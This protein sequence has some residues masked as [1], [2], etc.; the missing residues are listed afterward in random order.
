[1]SLLPST[2]SSIPPLLP[3]VPTTFSPHPPSFRN[4]CQNVTLYP[5]S[6]LPSSS[7]PPS[8]L[9]P[10]CLPISSLPAS[11]CGIQKVP[12]C[13]TREIVRRRKRIWVRDPCSQNGGKVI[14]IEGV[15]AN[16]DIDHEVMFTSVHFYVYVWTILLVIVLAWIIGYSGFTEFVPHLNLPQWSL[17]KWIILVVWTIFVILT[18][19][20]AYRANTLFNRDLQIWNNIFFFL[21]AILLLVLLFVFFVAKNL[22]WSVFIAAVLLIEIIIWMIFV[23]HVDH[24]G[25]FI[26][27]IYMLWLV[28]ILVLLFNIAKYN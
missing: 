16:T 10:S 18:L 1:M 12:V 28:Y 5:S 14:T 24:V 23:F 22:S 20:V 17:N 6:S 11:P 26:L 21:H 15:S 4:I 9:P 7:L 13:Q 3:P 25:F 27:F 19:Y 8:S 2:Y